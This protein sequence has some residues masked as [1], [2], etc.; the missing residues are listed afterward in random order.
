[1]VNSGK[2]ECK[3]QNRMTGAGRGGNNNTPSSLSNS[4]RHA[5]NEGWCYIQSAE[6]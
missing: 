1:M 5:H 6:K 3:S 4:G 2:N